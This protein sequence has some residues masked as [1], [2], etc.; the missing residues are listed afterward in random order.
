MS[1]NTL[2]PQ[3]DRPHT[4]NP[5]L[6]NLTEFP[7]DRLAAL[8]AKHQAEGLAQPECT[9]RA[10]EYFEFTQAAGPANGHAGL[11]YKIVLGRDDPKDN[12]VANCTCASK[13]CCKHI[14][15]AYFEAKE[16]RRFQV[17]FCCGCGA[18]FLTSCDGDYCFDCH[19]A[20]DRVM[21]IKSGQGRDNTC[22][23]CHKVGEESQSL[24]IG[25]DGTRYYAHSRC[26]VAARTQARQAVTA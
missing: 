23:Y 4:S 10:G 13:V 22:H 8:V 2:K 11:T 6:I 5:N 20:P 25:A 21:P 15:A 1:E 18:E 14:A 26:E 16:L 9:Q 24:W 3:A 17:K 12:V 7:K 19:T